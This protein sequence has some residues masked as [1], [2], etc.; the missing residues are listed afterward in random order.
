MFC[1]SEKNYA[2]PISII[3]A[4]I[5]ISGAMIFLGSFIGGAH[6]KTQVIS[7]LDEYIQDQ[8][9]AAQKQAAKAS[10]PK[11]ITADL[12]DDDAVEGDSDAKVT[13]VEFSDFQCPYCSKFYTDAYQD[14][15]KDYINTGK[16]K[17][18]FRDLPLDFHPGAM[19]AALAAECARDQGGDEAYFKMHDKLFADQK[20][21]FA[22]T[23]KEAMDKALKNAANQIG[24]NA[25]AFASCY[26]S[27]KYQSEI[28]KDK[29]DAAK[30]GIT[31][32]PAFVINGT[33]I[34]GAR[35]YA[36]FKAAIDKAL[37]EAK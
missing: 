35:P 11:I 16:V 37:E 1:N 14:I 36:T 33:Y 9:N 12:S 24:L 27:K 31:G 32:T 2:L 18:I 8:Q 23:S 13:I 10:E 34:S 29:N 7:A 26:D 25:S 15:L 20:T 19:P 5:L 22:D 17:L 3:I 6:L 21:I 28:E 4:A 30:V